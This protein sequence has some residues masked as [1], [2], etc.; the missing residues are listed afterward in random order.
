VVSALHAVPPDLYDGAGVVHCNPERTRLVSQLRTAL[1]PD[2]FD[3]GLSGES[4]EESAT[5]FA[6]R[7]TRSVVIFSG[8]RDLRGASI[9]EAACRAVSLEVTVERTSTNGTHHEFPERVGTSGARWIEIPL[10]AGAREAFLR[11]F[12]EWR[13][14]LGVGNLRL[15]P[16]PVTSFPSEPN[17]RSPLPAGLGLDDPEWRKDLLSLVA[18]HFPRRYP[19]F[20]C[21]VGA[22]DL[23]ANPAE[24]YYAG[25][26]LRERNAE[27]LV[28]IVDPS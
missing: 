23:G 6:R 17:R 9:L 13:S 12:W 8:P 21:A 22:H 4:A 5:R 3:D 11:T 7:G 19:A 10:D 20:L 27:L 24:D 14:Q 1:A 2:A 28:N 15:T 18:E 16:P 25:L 26:G